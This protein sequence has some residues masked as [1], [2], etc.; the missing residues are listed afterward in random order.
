MAVGV[1]AGLAARLVARAARV[2]PRFGRVVARVVWAGVG[3]VEPDHPH[4]RNVGD[5]GR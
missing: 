5:A 3:G 2:A 1:V 4:L